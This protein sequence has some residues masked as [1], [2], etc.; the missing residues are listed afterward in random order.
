MTYITAVSMLAV[1]AGGL[2]AFAVALLYWL[3]HRDDLR[4]ITAE[5]DALRARVAELEGTD[6]K[7]RVVHSLIQGASICTA[8]EAT[9]DPR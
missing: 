4:E 8:Q 9:R 1:S 3:N 7:P 5:R 6:G 2:A